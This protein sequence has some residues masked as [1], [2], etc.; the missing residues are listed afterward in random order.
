MILNNNVQIESVDF[1]YTIFERKDTKPYVS[2][3]GLTVTTAVL[4][5]F[6]YSYRTSTKQSNF[7]FEVKAGIWASEEIFER[8]LTGDTDKT[9]PIDTYDIMFSLD[10]QKLTSQNDNVLGGDIKPWLL[11]QVNEILAMISD[12][13]NYGCGVW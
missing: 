8:W 12:E 1:K 3:S 9:E 13:C 5:P 6:I 4:A 11:C 10:G 7:K 2:K